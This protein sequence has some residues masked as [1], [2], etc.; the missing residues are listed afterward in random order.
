MIQDIS[1]LLL[2]TTD[3]N[4]AKIIEYTRRP[5]PDIEIMNARLIQFWNETVEPD[6][7]VFHLGDFLFGG[8]GDAMQF[9]S[10]L[11]GRIF[12]L[13]NQHHHDHG[14]LPKTF[15]SSQFKSAAGY[16]VM[17]L[18]P[19]H[20]WTDKVTRL[21]LCHFPLAE[22]EGKHHGTIHLHGHSHGAFHDVGRSID[23]GVDSHDFRPIPLTEIKRWVEHSEV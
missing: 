16:P 11:N 12:V 19:I 3:F 13:S 2:T 7:A 23:V 21:V 1:G 14:W 10:R 5:F 8:V 9:F 6:D 18:P 17:L 22:W 20:V 15:G 4:H